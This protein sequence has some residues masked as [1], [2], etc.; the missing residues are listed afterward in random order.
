MCMDKPEDTAKSGCRCQL[1]KIRWWSGQGSSLWGMFTRTHWH[2]QS[3]WQN[4]EMCSYWLV[5]AATQSP[6]CSHTAAASL[7]VPSNL[8]IIQQL[9]LLPSP[10]LQGLAQLW[11]PSRLVGGCHWSTSCWIFSVLLLPRRLFSPNWNLFPLSL[12]YC[13]LYFPLGTHHH[14]LLGISLVLRFLSVGT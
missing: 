7:Q 4:A 9:E 11:Q 1:K 13:L 12:E 10:G 8:Q 5:L 6:G 14:H 3:S 2:R